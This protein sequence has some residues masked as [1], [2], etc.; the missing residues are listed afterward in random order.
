MG[1]E[2]TGIS[3]QVL[4]EILALAKTHGLSKV[5]LFGSRARGDFCPKSDIDL[6]AEGNDIAAFAMDVDEKT[7]T[8]LRYD[9]VDVAKVPEEL[10]DIILKEGIVLYEKI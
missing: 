6:A 1:L 8:L 9:I 7:E 2:N 4:E 10:L 5:I 3:Q